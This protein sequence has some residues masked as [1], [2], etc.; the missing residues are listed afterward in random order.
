MRDHS[1]GQQVRLGEYL[2]KE[3]PDVGQYTRGILLS[4]FQVVV[5]SPAFLADLVFMVPLVEL[6]QEPDH[7]G[8]VRL[9]VLTLNEPSLDVLYAGYTDDEGIVTTLYFL[10]E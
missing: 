7:P 2:V 10:V 4:P 5:H 6:V 1:L 9:I 8:R 3:F